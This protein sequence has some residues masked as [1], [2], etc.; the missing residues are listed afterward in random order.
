VLL[1]EKN[2][3]PVHCK[4]H[5]MKPTILALF[6]VLLFVAAF[7][8]DTTFIEQRIYSGK[9][10]KVINGADTTRVGYYKSG[11]LE[12]KRAF[13]T[14]RAPY[15]Y[16]RWYETGQLMWEKNM[17]NSVENGSCTYYNE[18]GKKVAEFIYEK[19]SI[20]DT[21]FLDATTNLVLGNATYYSVVVGGAV[22]EG[23]PSTPVEQDIPY[24]NYP[25]YLVK[26]KDEKAIPQV[27]EKFETDENGR[28]IL[29]LKNG[30]YGFFPQYYDIKSLSPGEY[31]PAPAMSGSTQSNW[32][33]QAPLKIEKPGLIFFRLHFSSIG[34]AP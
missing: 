18:K 20:S 25:F 33:M 23:M 5:I 9:V 19:G 8:Q 10:V 2:K 13:I 27:I 4:K 7:A 32:N 1:A 30:A 16:T 6:F 22:Y 24:T 26:I 29:C 21:I 15:I 12:S 34:Y 14:N 28:F 17:K 11:A 3:T 31:C